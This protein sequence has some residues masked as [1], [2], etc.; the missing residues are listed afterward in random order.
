VTDQPW[1][2]APLV[3]IDLE[4]TGAQDREN[5]AILELALVPFT[6]GVR[7]VADAFTTLV[8][9]GRPVPQRPWI[10]P[11]LTDATLAT[12]PRWAAVA[13]EVT[14]RVDGH[15]LVGHNVSVD[16]RLLSRYAPDLR[17]AGILDTY[18]L[19][20]A[21]DV[22]GSLGLTA[23]VT[24]LGLEDTVRAAVPDGQP[25]R[26]LWDT[27]ATAM[28]LPVFIQLLWPTATPTIEGVAACSEAAEPPRSTSQDALF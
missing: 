24:E 5:E 11:G 21:A 2:T 3:A 12:A 1:H 13:G 20:R 4:G 9:P 28:L 23:I 25:H 10:S 26:A 27:V 15:W 18:R 17:V 16:W 19:A 22:P 14:K 8:N 6:E 7:A